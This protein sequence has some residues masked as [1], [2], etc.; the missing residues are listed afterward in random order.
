M[1]D[2]FTIAMLHSC[3][4]FLDKRDFRFPIFGNQMN[5]IIITIKYCVNVFSCFYIDRPFILLE[6]EFELDK[7]KL[8]F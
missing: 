3:L 6:N 4:K 2:A 8:T 1:I 5:W 7:K